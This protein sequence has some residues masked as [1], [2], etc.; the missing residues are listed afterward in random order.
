MISA[1]KFYSVVN[2]LKRK[3]FTREY[4]VN[5]GGRGGITT[6]LEITEEGCKAIEVNPK[7]HLTRGGNFVT[8]IFVTKLNNNFRKMLAHCRVSLEKQVQGKF[9]DI[10]IESVNQSFVVAVEVE[11]SDANLQINME[12]DSDRADF[13]IEACIDQKLMNKAEEIVKALP[14]EKQIKVGICLLTKLIKCSTK[15]SDLV[16]S[17]IL[18]EKGL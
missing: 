16:D 1:S 7:P 8:D 14:K 4:V 10:V 12:K 11:L 9:C 13:V 17:E 18:K 15:L 5:L 2:T 3:G 6:F